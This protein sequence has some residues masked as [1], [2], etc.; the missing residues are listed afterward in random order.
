MRK[1]IT[2]GQLALSLKSCTNYSPFQEGMC[3]Q[4]K[5]NRRWQ[6]RGHRK[7]YDT[8]MQPLYC[9]VHVWRATIPPR[10]AVSHCQRTTV[11]SSSIRAQKS[12][13][14]GSL[15]LCCSALSNSLFKALR[16]I[17]DSWWLALQAPY[18]TYHSKLK[19]PSCPGINSQLTG[20]LHT[21]YCNCS[22]LV[23][24]ALWKFHLLGNQLSTQS[25]S[26]QSVQELKD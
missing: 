18:K 23:P 13:L 21:L 9:I 10:C 3:M 26:H 22:L 24:K 7:Y 19:Q 16:S 1:F 6:R 17:Q 4:G 12:R 14:Q 11:R 5:K 2:S 25:P 15:F 8:S 20:S